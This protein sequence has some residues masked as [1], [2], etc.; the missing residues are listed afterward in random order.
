MCLKAETLFSQLH[1][2]F[3]SVNPPPMHAHTRVHTHTHTHTHTLPP[4][5][6]AHPAHHCLVNL[7]KTPICL[8]DLNGSF[9]WLRISPG[10]AQSAPLL[11]FVIQLP[12]QA[13]PVSSLPQSS[14]PNSSPMTCW[15]P[16]L[17]SGCAPLPEY[18]PFLH[19][20]AG[21]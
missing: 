15:P 3:S 13:S 7:L 19:P 4:P 6:L 2:P 17:Y 1:P 11:S 10:T 21:N 8:S 20:A 16:G 5:T 9:K 14:R 18:W 12:Y